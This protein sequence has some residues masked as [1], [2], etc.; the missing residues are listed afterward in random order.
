MIGIDMEKI[1]GVALKAG[2]GELDRQ[3]AVPAPALPPRHAR[4]FVGRW[5]IRAVPTDLLNGN[6][7][8]SYTNVPVFIQR[9]TDHHVVIDTVHTG[10][11][12]TLDSRYMDG[13]VAPPTK[14]TA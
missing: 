6:R 14:E 1:L 2:V 9:V 13:W 7:D 4:N 10:S 8:W 3:M 5:A 11:G 12:H